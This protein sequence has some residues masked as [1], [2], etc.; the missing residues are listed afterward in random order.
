MASIN[1]SDD[2]PSDD[3]GLTRTLREFTSYI[4]GLEPSD[5]TPTDRAVLRWLLNDLKE[6][7]DRAQL[8][9]QA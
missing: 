6:I 7:R 2:Y 1:N 4:K 3:M 8:E 9:G 5:L